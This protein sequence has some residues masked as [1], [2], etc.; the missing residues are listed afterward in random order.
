[1]RIEQVKGE[2]ARHQVG[3]LLTACEEQVGVSV[4]KCFVSVE[5]L[6]RATGREDISRNRSAS[7]S[8]TG[9]HVCRYTHMFFFFDLFY[10]LFPS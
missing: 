8:I 5:S 6:C 7:T 2:S 10:K 3:T 1:M 9:S 4:T